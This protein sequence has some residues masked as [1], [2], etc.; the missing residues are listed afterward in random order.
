MNSDGVRLS[1]ATMIRY[2][3]CLLLCSILPL[4]A[5]AEDSTPRAIYIANMGAMQPHPRLKRADE[6][7]EDQ[8][9]LSNLS[10]HDRPMNR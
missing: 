10:E 8:R 1:I 5:T 3:A 7:R 2:T 6:E 9:D 4:A